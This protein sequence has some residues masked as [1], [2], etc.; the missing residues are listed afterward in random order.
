MS[1]GGDALRR[2]NSQSHPPETITRRHFLRAAG[3]TLALPWL[4]SL[5]R[6]EAA[7]A[8]RRMVFIMTNMGVLPRYFFP[9]KAGRDY[10]GTPY[11][12]LLVAHR[13]RFTFFSGV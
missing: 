1:R 9:E 7:S 2:C 10:A 8:L 13:D 12:D 6:A 11:L 5:A 4:E 3:A